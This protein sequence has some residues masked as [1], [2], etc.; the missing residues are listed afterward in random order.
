[1][2]K[3]I[4]KLQHLEQ[5]DRQVKLQRAQKDSIYIIPQHTMKVASQTKEGIAETSTQKKINTDF[6]P[7]TL[8]KIILYELYWIYIAKFFPNMRTR[9]E[10]TH[11]DRTS[12]RPCLS[13]SLQVSQSPV[14]PVPRAWH[15][16]GRVNAVGMNAIIQNLWLRFFS[17]STRNYAIV[18]SLVVDEKSTIIDWYS[19]TGDLSFLWLFSNFFLCLQFSEV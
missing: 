3:C 13:P 18:S 8:T 9:K 7:Y 12:S 19:P 14:F 5:L 11:R 4:I 17:F 15:T 10:A 1:M 2:L 16:Q 6:P